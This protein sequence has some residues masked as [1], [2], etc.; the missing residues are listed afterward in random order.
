[1]SESAHA[2]RH[3]RT[4][5]VSL[6]TLYQNTKLRRVAVLLLCGVLAYATW[7]AI[8]WQTIPGTDQFVWDIPA[9]AKG[10]LLVTL[11]GGYYVL[12]R[13]GGLL[14]RDA[15]KVYASSTGLR[16]STTSVRWYR[17]LN[18]VGPLYNLYLNRDLLRQF[19]RREIEGRY[20]GSYLGIVWSMILPLM[21]LAIYT[22]VFSV[23]FK[24]HWQTDANESQGE[25]A[26]TLFAGL[27]A[28]NI[29]SECVN[30]APTLITTNPNYVKKVVFPLEILSASTL[31]AALFHS[32]ISIAILLIAKLLIMGTLSVTLMLLPLAVLPLIGLC[33][34]L[35]WFLAS[36]G[37][38]VRDTAYAISIVT[39]VLFFM[40]AIFYPISAVPETLQPIMYLNPLTS[41][42]ESFRQTLIWNQPLNWGPWLIITLISGVITVLGYT[43]FMKTKG[44]FADVI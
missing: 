36:L 18:P 17:Y 24:S 32:L 31:G 44:G 7:V 28:F 26:L 9:W 30:R 34:G 23:I 42:V 1:L 25:F 20:R 35:G 13:L 15:R 33:L 11:A 29:F 3:N 22:F 5:S 12:F 27:I 2:N 37:V 21:M 41:I 19:T 39:Q 14:I 38:Y 16:S 40:S 6:T 10:L 43:W 8:R 4:R